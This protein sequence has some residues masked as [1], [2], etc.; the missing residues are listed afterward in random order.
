MNLF[1]PQ[2]AWRWMIVLRSLKLNPVNAKFQQIS[3]V[4]G[5]LKRIRTYVT[6]VLKESGRSVFLMKPNLVSLGQPSAPQ[7]LGVFFKVKLLWH[8]KF[9]WRLRTRLFFPRFR[10][11]SFNRRM[12]QEQV[13]HISFGP[14]NHVFFQYAV[15]RN[16][17]KV[18]VDYSF[19]Y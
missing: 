13:F 2:C 7:Q 5:F 1:I 9:S 6:N 11:T 12:Q 3:W 4:T 15:R 19:S 8:L 16:R 17:V 10:K 14:F 18:S